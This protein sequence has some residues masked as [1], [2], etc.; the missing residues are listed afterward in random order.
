MKPEDGSGPSNMT[1]YIQVDELGPYRDKIVAAGGEI[2][3]EEKEVPHVG[4]FSLF[5]DTD[6]RVIGIWKQAVMANNE[7]CCGG[8]SCS[9]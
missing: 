1:F 4:W 6:G 3:V 2:L 9:S 8:D 7:A 5:K